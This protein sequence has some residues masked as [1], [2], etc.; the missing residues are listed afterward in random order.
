MLRVD[1]RRVG[2]IVAR[3]KAVRP[4]R[5]DLRCVQ[6]KDEGYVGHG[7]GLVH[8]G[9]SE[10]IDLGVS[11]RVHYLLEP[12][13]QRK[14]T[15][16]A[17]AQSGR[18]NHL[19]GTIDRDVSERCEPAWGRDRNGSQ[20]A[21]VSGEDPPGR[22]RCA[23]AAENATV[24]AELIEGDPTP[25]L[26][27]PAAVESAISVLELPSPLKMAREVCSW[28]RRMRRFPLR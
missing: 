16:A 12:A 6:G 19:A 18:K 3:C 5:E 1:E 15:L 13:C 23:N 9:I 4:Y 11:V 7:A 28:S 8:D 2:W 14:D 20:G 27:N 22:P 25:C 17:I 24:P 10:G 26:K 21:A